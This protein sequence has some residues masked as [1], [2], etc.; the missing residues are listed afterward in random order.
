M[1]LGER[2]EHT[3]L[4]VCLKQASSGGGRSI[5]KALPPGWFHPDGEDSAHA[6]WLGANTN[7]NAPHSSPSDMGHASPGP[8]DDEQ[9]A[10]QEVGDEDEAAIDEEDES[11]WITLDNID[12]IVP[13][14]CEA[15]APVGDEVEDRRVACAT[16][17]FAMQNTLLQIGLSACRA[18]D[19]LSR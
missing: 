12:R 3:R 5:L 1:E 13:A 7:A 18:H 17:D 8:H 10:I 6:A 15:R 11:A 19:L 4:S 2:F 16:T 9:P 14:G